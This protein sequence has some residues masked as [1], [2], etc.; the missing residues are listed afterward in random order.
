MPPLRLASASIW[1]THLAARMYSS[2]LTCQPEQNSQR[3]LS[4]VWQ[5]AGGTLV[6]IGPEWLNAPDERGGRRLEYPDDWVRLEISQALKRNIVVI[7]VRVDRTQL[8]A[9]EAL[10]EDIRGLLDHQAVF[11]TVPGFRNEMLGLCA[12]YPSHLW[13]PIVA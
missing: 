12:G 7:P 11:V 10:P 8:P 3:C 2:I 9:R 4:S 6:L 1:N 5:N 13:T